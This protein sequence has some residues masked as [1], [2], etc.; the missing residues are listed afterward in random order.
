[1]SIIYSKE[2][3]G[4]LNVLVSGKLTRDPEIKHLPKGDKI[5]FSIAYGAKKY[6]DCEVWADNAV[7]QL[8]GCLEKGD[9]IAATGSHRSWE[10]NGKTYHSIDVDAI[11]TM[12]MPPIS[13]SGSSEHTAE[14]T[15]QFEELSEEDESLP[16]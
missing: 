4:T 3:D 16:F 10:Y 14:A 8:A 9:T 2:Q 1:M 11:F 7:G 15:P 13:T 12:N 5:R 6:M